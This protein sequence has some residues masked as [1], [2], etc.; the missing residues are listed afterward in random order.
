M[1]L[2]NGLQGDKEV[3]EKVPATPSVDHVLVF[4][5][6]GGVDFWN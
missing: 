4:R 1:S 5:N 2:G 6:G 3:L